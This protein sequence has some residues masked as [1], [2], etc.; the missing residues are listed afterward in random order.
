[1]NLH[2]PLFLLLFYIVCIMSCSQDTEIATSEDEPF[3]HLQTTTV[4][5]NPCSTF[6]DLGRLCSNV[7]RAPDDSG[8]NAPTPT[9]SQC[10]KDEIISTYLHALD[11]S[12]TPANRI[13]VE[14]AIDNSG[15]YCYGCTHVFDV[16]RETINLL[17]N[18]DDPATAASVHLSFLK[19][20]VG[21]ED[22]QLQYFVGLGPLST[23]VTL[24]ELHES[25]TS[26]EC[27]SIA[28]IHNLHR[29]LIND[30]GAILEEGIF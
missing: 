20:I 18:N 29:I 14:Q 26:D 27:I 4:G 25:E 10:K 28:T 3:R 11:F 17:N 23:E 6:N 12:D 1:M 8:V 16:T 19:N 30:E 24:R 5:E 7:D 22:N 13:L 2:F 21:L 15:F 9:K